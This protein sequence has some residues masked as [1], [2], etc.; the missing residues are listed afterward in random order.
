MGR[1]ELGVG[2]NGGLRPSPQLREPSMRKPLIHK[3]LTTGC[4]RQAAE[5]KRTPGWNLPSIQVCG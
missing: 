2:L 4:W 3:V 1:T 5:K